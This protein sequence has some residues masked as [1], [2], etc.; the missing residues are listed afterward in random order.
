MQR[1]YRSRALQCTP[2]EVLDM[3][4]PTEFGYFPAFARANTFVV[5]S[6]P[7][8]LVCAMAVCRPCFVCCVPCGDLRIS[9]RSGRPIVR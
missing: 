8:Q 4:P 2:E 7:C 6:L 9:S 1:C 3:W 5:S